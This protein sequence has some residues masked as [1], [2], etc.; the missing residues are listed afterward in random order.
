VSYLTGL[1]SA[2]PVPNSPEFRR[3]DSLPRR[4]PTEPPPGWEDRW[5]LP[6]CGDPKCH[7]H[8]PLWPAQRIALAEA[9]ANKGLLGLLG[10]GAGKALTS[11]LLPTV[12]GARRPALFV[13]SSL[14]DQTRRILEDVR[15]HWVIIPPTIIPYGK[16]QHPKYAD[17]VEEADPDCFVFDEAH[18]VSSSDSARAKRVKRALKARPHA[19][20]CPLSGTMIR[21]GLNDWSWLAAYALRPGSPA[22]RDW[23]TT[24][25]WGYAL[26][27]LGALDNAPP[28][29]LARWC[30]DGE[31]PRAGYRRRIAD[32]PGV[33][34]ASTLSCDASI[35]IHQRRPRVPGPVKDALRNARDLW[36]RPDGAYYESA[37]DHHRYGMQLSLGLYLRWTE[38]PPR[39]WIDARR[40]WWSE[41]RRS[42]RRG[43]RG[44]D[45][46]ALYE[47]AVERGDIHSPTY[48]AWRAVRDAYAPKTE[49]VW[50]SDFLLQDAARWAEEAPGI[51]WT[52]TPEFAERL[53]EQTGLPYYGAGS[54]DPSEV[55]DGSRSI[56]ASR[57]A[58]GTGRNLVPWHRMLI[59][60][61]PSN[62]EAFEQTIARCHRA[63]QKS[64]EV[65]VWVYR[66]T[67]ETQ[68]AFDRAMSNSLYVEEQSPGAKRRLLLATRT[69][70]L[71][72][73]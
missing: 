39:E 17:I 34:T 55:E 26:D 15:Q 63:H 47:A 4:T 32:T 22:P 38:T 25:A 46:P 73:E 59:T 35:V 70:G 24:K 14:E 31:S 21:H 5:R 18:Q 65:L 1:F 48:G 10:A 29:V 44:R 72:G 53:A 2:P 16:L 11:L 9:A 6:G 40:A 58:H 61:S 54:R 57:D 51:V 69:W 20:V 71:D 13:P 62:D 67:E 27:D 50:L 7:Y 36:A 37:L 52:D 33:V 30:K 41:V 42:I 8:G 12:L 68:D 3:V 45:S 64:D 56:I 43:A 66:H 19:P 28:G 60:E 23:R 49:A